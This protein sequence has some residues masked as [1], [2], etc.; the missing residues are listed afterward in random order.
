MESNGKKKVMEEI[1]KYR[2]KSVYSHLPEDCSDAC[3]AR[4]KIRK[5][6]FVSYNILCSIYIVTYNDTA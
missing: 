2:A 4:G 3:K 6:L 1:D 5:K